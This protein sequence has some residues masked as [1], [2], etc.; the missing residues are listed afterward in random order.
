MVE[1]DLGVGLG[2]SDG[3]WVNFLEVIDVVVFADGIGTMDS[4][5]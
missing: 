3:G 2:G 5:E 4:V 1:E